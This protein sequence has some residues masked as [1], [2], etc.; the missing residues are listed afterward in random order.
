LNSSS[1]EDEGDP[2]G[3]EL[4]VLWS[5]TPLLCEDRPLLGIG[6]SPKSFSPIASIRC[7][8]LSSITNAKNYTNKRA[9]KKK[10]KELLSKNGRYA[11]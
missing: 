5:C 6:L 2:L 4:D 7:K 10:K 3:L 9:E 1:V 8:I 11:P